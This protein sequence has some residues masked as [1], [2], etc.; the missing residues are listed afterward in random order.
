[1][2]QRSYRKTGM[3]PRMIKPLPVY[4]FGGAN[5]TAPLYRNIQLTSDAVM[6]AIQRT[7]NVFSDYHSVGR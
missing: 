2:Q 7:G 4:P 5:R 6:F 1:M 3:I